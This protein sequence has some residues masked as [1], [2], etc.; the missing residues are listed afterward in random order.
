[1]CRRGSLSLIGRLIFYII[2][3]LILSLGVSLTLL[4]GMGIGSWEA[5]NIGLSRT[6]EISITISYT[7]SGILLIAINSILSRT[8]PDILALVTTFLIGF[9]VDFWS[10]VVKLNTFLNVHEFISIFIF[11][12]GILITSTG[13]SLYLQ[14]KMAASPVDNFM[15]TIMKL[16]G[17]SIKYSKIATE[18]IGLL[19]AFFFSGPIGFGTLLF[20]ILLGPLIE[21]QFNYIKKKLSSSF[22]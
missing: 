10:H 9:L 7:I 11:I 12:F 4:S 17:W 15:M 14:S 19:L 20:V 13:V 21:I 8:R 2:G 16:T 22:L 3:L 6:F 18:L 5:F 1:M